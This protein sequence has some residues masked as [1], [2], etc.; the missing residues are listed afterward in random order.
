MGNK[1]HSFLPDSK[2]KV[3]GPFEMK[4]RTAADHEEVRRDKSCLL[5]TSPSPRD[6]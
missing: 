1:F 3:D 5:Y 4:V 6:A 2:I